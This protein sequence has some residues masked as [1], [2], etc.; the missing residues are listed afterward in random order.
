MS[1]LVFPSRI[2]EQHLVVLGKTGA[3]KSSALRHIVEH[4]L[5]RKKRVCVID[6]K[7]DWWGIKWSADGKSAGFPIVA[8]G[9][10]KESKASDIPLNAQ[11]G[12]HVAELVASGNRPCILGFR[13]W[14]TSHL[15]RFW[16][17]FAPTLFNANAGE[18]YLIGD[19][20]HNLAPKGKILDPDAGKCLHWSNRLIN[21]GRGIGLVCLIASQRPQKVHNDTLTACETLVAMRVIHKADRD[22][23]KEWIEG[24]GDLKQGREVLDS[25]AGLKRGSGW[26]WSPENHFGPQVV[27]FPMFKTFDSFAPPQLQ[28]SVTMSDWGNVD[29]DAVRTKLASV[30]EEHRQNDPAELK[31]T[32][33]ALRKELAAKQPAQPMKV[34]TKEVSVFTSDDRNMVDRISLRLKEIC[35]A[36]AKGLGVMDD[37]RSLVTMVVSRI[38]AHLKQR[39]VLAAPLLRTAVPEAR[40]VRPQRQPA[41]TSNGEPLAKAERAILRVLA[42]FPEGKTRRE[43]GVVAGYKHSGGGFNNALSALRARGYVIGSD[44]V[45]ITDEGLRAYGPVEPLPTG[46]ELY[47]YWMQHPDLGRA[48]QEVLRVLF[49]YRKSMPKEVI[50]PL[51]ISDRGTP[52]EANGGGFNNA[53]SRLRTYELIEGSRGELSAAKE[54]FE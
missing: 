34:E 35:D 25:L 52:Y 4:L 41:A 6:P 31:R 39:P 43:I 19:E 22:A 20:F 17:D 47:D 36:Q 9:D 30:I 21:E 18:L 8:F 3:G 11:S 12:K 40:P 16:I 54:F 15:V 5:A 53:I 13:G 44:P 32:I 38:E 10:F 1:D 45:R 46:K 29:L 42:N 24:C 2:L 49:T 51:T 33:S 7:G 27:E 14:M 23:V 26:V 50:A 37:A 28:K 48:E